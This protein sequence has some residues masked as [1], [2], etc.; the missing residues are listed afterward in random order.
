MLH[1]E[2]W[3]KKEGYFFEV[4]IV[5]KKKSKWQDI[6][7]ADSREFGR[8][9]VLNNIIQLAEK[10]EFVYH[11]S[12]VHPSLVRHKKAKRVAILGGGDGCAARE[13]LKHKNI[14]EVVMVDLDKE[15]VDISKKYLT[16]S[17][18]WKDK[19]L[20]VVIDD[21][22]NL[23]GKF[24]VVFADLVDPTE[25]VGE[26]YSLKQFKE[27]K[28]LLNKDGIMVSHCEGPMF[29]ANTMQNMVS[30]FKKVFKH[31]DYYMTYV[32]SFN[33]MWGFVMGSDKNYFN[34][35][36]TVPKIELKHYSKEIDVAMHAIPKYLK[37]TFKKKNPKLGV[38]FEKGG[39]VKNLGEIKL[40]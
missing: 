15:V 24:D 3:N 28:N 39:F 9:L 38:S 1:Y 25:E 26:L 21:A 14:K 8:V 30:M 32:R 6:V 16:W 13:I 4:K 31:V 34:K 11:E 10:D 36:I 20:K 17:N 37:D 40:K 29:E 35:K 33:S 19:R 27:F 18:P 22:R 5:K 7:V 23:K 2:L 12:L